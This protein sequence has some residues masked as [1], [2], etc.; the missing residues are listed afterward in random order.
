M[1]SQLRAPLGQPTLNLV[2]QPIIIIVVVG[3]SYSLNKWTPPPLP[4]LIVRFAQFEEEGA[5]FEFLGYESHRRN[6]RRSSDDSQG[7]ELSRQARHHIPPRHLNS[8]LDSTTAVDYVRLDSKLLLL[9]LPFARIL[10]D[11]LILEAIH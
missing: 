3:Q 2:G 7:H 5:I 9:S 4:L 11:L 1:C 10:R 8:Y 6:L